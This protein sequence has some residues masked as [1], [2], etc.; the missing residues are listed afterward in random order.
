M[1]GKSLSIKLSS[2]TELTQNPYGHFLQYALNVGVNGSSSSKVCD[3]VLGFDTIFQLNLR[4]ELEQ[5]RFG[6]G[7]QDN[8]D[9]SLGQTPC[10]LSSDPICGSSDYF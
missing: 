4:A 3:N 7:Y 8:V 10:V 9:A 1:G 2:S 5:L 6:A